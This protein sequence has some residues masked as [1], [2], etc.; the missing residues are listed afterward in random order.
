MNTNYEYLHL[1]PV[2]QL[3]YSGE[4]APDPRWMRRDGPENL[5][6]SGGEEKYPYPC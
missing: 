2:P 1:T 6:G 5:C 4:R 3:L